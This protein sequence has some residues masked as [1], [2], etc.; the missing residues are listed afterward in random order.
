V[1]EVELKFRVEDP[2]ALDRKLI[3]LA[4]RFRDPVTQVDRY[5]AHPS[6]DFVRTD[7]AL[8][9]RQ[10][11][12]DVA[13]TWKGPRID[14]ATKTRRELE[15][16]LAPLS[17]A[18]GRPPGGAA[19]IER[20]TELLEALGFRR[21]REVVKRRRPARVPWQ[22]AEVDVAVDELAGLGTFL[23]LEILARQGELPQ[24]R[25]CLESLA[26]ELGC[27]DPERRSYLEL[28]L[29]RR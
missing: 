25:G 6:R 18:A 4:A 28:V 2:A 23:E 8:R 22:G 27:T 12:D 3:A 5:F 11:G 15:L 17:P 24:A 10:T 29:E 26:R 9:L 20:W 19:T 16:D 13:I 21:V 14:T 1:Y 7:E